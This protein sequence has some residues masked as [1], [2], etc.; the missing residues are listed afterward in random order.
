MSETINKLDGQTMEFWLEKKI[1]DGVTLSGFIDFIINS[2]PEYSYEF[3]E[4]KKKIARNNR[5]ALSI[6]ITM[7]REIENDEVKILG[8][9]FI[10]VLM[11]NP[12]GF[13]KAKKPK[14]KP[15]N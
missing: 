14:L 6:L 7:L 10:Q 12:K 8:K 5:S 11:D 9:K 15:M 4:L 1:D 13:K 3:T 2:Y